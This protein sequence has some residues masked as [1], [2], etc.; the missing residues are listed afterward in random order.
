MSLPPRPTHADSDTSPFTSSPLTL[1]FISIARF[2]AL[3]WSGSPTR[4][5]PF[6]ARV[7]TTLPCTGALA[8]LARLSADHIG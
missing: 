4:T 3:P 5:T 8:R 7:L 1:A 6:S 2:W